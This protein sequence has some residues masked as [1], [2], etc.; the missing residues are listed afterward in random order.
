MNIPGFSTNGLLLMHRGVV[1]ALAADDALP[2]GQDK[3]YGVREYAD[4]REHGDAIEA[5]LSARGVSFSKI[6][7]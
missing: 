1:D 4:W 7:W 5:E 6:G 3:I 2:I